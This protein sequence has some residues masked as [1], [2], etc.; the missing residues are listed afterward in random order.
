M[1]LEIDIGIVIKG[2]QH[3]PKLPGVLGLSHNKMAAAVPV[4]LG[5]H[6]SSSVDGDFRPFFVDKGSSLAM[7]LLDFAATLRL[8]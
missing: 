4:Q 8:P 2:R 5:S 1:F 7:G 6:Q 3:N